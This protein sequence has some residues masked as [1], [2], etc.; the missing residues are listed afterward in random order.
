MSEQTSAQEE[1]KKQRKK[2]KKKQRGKDIRK[3]M[4]FVFAFMS[5]PARHYRCGM[6][7]YRDYYDL[8][9]RQPRVNPNLKQFNLLKSY[10][11]HRVE[12]IAG[13]GIVH[14]INAP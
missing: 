11:N 13:T 4:P 3:G 6:I 14:I 5:D 7:R 1:K 8:I 12:F 2:E 9:P 10:Q